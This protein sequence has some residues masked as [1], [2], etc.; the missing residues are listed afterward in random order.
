MVRINGESD[1]RFAPVEDA[2]QRNFED[3]GE[4]G[5]ALC[6]YSN[7]RPVV[8]LWGGYKDAARAESWER[9]TIV[10]VYSVTKGL[11]ALSVHMLVERGL[12]DLDTPVSE[13]WPEF[14]Q[15]GKK[16]V[17]PRHILSHTAGL[18]AFD[19][20]MTVDE[21]FDWD[22][23][24]SRLAQQKPRWEPGTR[25]GYQPATFG[26]LAGE[27]IR[28]VSGKSPGAFL[29]SEVVEPLGGDFHVGTDEK[30]DHR[31]AELLPVTAE[32]AANWGSPDTESLAWKAT[33]NPDV[34]IPAVANSVKWRR[35]ELPGA[36]GHGDARTVARTYAALANGGSLDGTRLLSNDAVEQM[37]QEQVAETDCVLQ[38]EGRIALGYALNGGWFRTT[39][40]PRSFGYPGLGGHMAFADPDAKIGFGYVANQMKIPA[41]FR[42]PRVGRILDALDG[43]L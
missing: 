21:Y 26:H 13:Y 40:N 32:E 31:V 11:T 4:V 14:A 24:V 39:P 19:E 3:L 16:A 1:Q 8:D 12:L 37:T 18:P 42:D 38:L 36:N 35:A 28:R 20:P 6:I 34:G 30:H 29:R 27:L 10:C 25:L 23:V 9:D 22:L 33:S 7:G 5:A 41:D 2:F 17:T 43:C 15:N